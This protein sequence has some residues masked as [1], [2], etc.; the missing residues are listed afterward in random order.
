MAFKLKKI[1]ID[2]EGLEKRKKNS[3]VKF[4][5]EGLH[6][7]TVKGVEKRTSENGNAF[8]LIEFVNGTQSTKHLIWGL[9]DDFPYDPS[10][11]AN[12]LNEQLFATL[13][14]VDFDPHADEFTENLIRCFE[15]L[16]TN[17]FK[18]MHARIRVGYS[19]LHAKYIKN[20]GQSKG[21]FILSTRAGVP[22]QGYEEKK[23]DSNG[24]V[25]A[26]ITA[27][28]TTRPENKQFRFHKFPEIQE[29]LPPK[30]SN[31]AFVSRVWS[32]EEAD[33]DDNSF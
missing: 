3:G 2:K 1:S 10:K 5:R 32:K 8:Y 16:D 28:N 14:G 33:V 9:R 24:A 4:F 19:G 6:D 20:E 23:F 27:L 13:L 30:E 29:F 22:L 17:G 15:L 7:V 11:R 18:G 26:E 25:E 12:I 21:H 31:S